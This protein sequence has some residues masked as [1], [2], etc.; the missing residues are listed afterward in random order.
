MRFSPY[1]DRKEGE[2]RVF[3]WSLINVQGEENATVEYSNEAFRRIKNGPL[4]T[5]TDKLD[6][7]SA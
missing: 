4:S 3:L 2:S 1:F 7:F 5:S 6:K